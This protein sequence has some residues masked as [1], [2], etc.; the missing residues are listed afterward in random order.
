VPANS[1]GDVL[2]FTPYRI[3]ASNYHREGK[4]L[5]DIKRLETAKT[6]ESE[7]DALTER[8]VNAM[9]YCPSRLPGYSWQRKVAEDGKYPAWAAPVSG[10][11]FMEAAGPLPVL[12][13]VRN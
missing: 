8:R 11:R 1:G 2:Y 3:I 7:H 4:G 12:I 13:R 6:A 9:L 10:L 5:K